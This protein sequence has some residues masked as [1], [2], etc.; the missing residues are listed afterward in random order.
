MNTSINKVTA[1]GWAA[2]KE[3]WKLL[4]DRE[5][6]EEP[7]KPSPH[8]PP[9]P[10]GLALLHPI[11]D[12]RLNTTLSAGIKGKW[13]YYS[14]ALAVLSFVSNWGG[15]LSIFNVMVAFLAALGLQ[16][17]TSAAGWELSHA[18][19]KRAA[20]FFLAAW[21]L[22]FAVSIQFDGIYFNGLHRAKQ[23]ALDRPVAIQDEAQQGGKA[24]ADIIAGVKKADLAALGHES[25]IL[26]DAG[27]KARTRQFQAEQR[28]IQNAFAL[29]AAR[30]EQVGIARA[31]QRK[32]LIDDQ[33]KQVEALSFDTSQ[34][35]SKKP[36]QAWPLIQQAYNQ[37]AN[38]HASI[39]SAMTDQKYDMPPCPQPT[40]AGAQDIKTGM[41]DTLGGP[42]SQ[43]FHPTLLQGFFAAI[44]AAFELPPLLFSLA[45]ASMRRDSRAKK[46]A[47][48]ED[49]DVSA[50]AAEDDDARD[51]EGEQAAESDP[52]E[53]KLQDYERHQR[54]VFR[55]GEKLEAD[56]EAE[57]MLKPIAQACR[58][59]Q[60]GRLQNH[61]LRLDLEA[62]EENVGVQ[63]EYAER[64]GIRQEKVEEM[65]EAEFGEFQA[66]RSLQR[67][68]AERE[69]ERRSKEAELSIA[70]EITKLDA[71]LSA[72]G[73]PA[74]GHPYDDLKAV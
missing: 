6:L 2:V 7:D 37:A 46:G 42:L 56:A 11:L 57:V 70:R 25:A 31:N 40:V 29:Q 26:D 28:P 22:C 4:T 72:L 63:R 65:V 10:T 50:E 39:R 35:A 45:F 17:A 34:I 1:A 61:A 14:V 51:E 32:E 73:R 67:K 66:E 3:K 36:E 9:R 33:I 48:S 24:V 13:F 38:V 18:V 15:F 21:M 69:R 20:A 16:I 19:N 68:I 41:S 23:V 60:C 43:V 27:A 5:H 53:R 44:A 8:K 52:D 58:R 74:E 47:R 49:K 54:F 12:Y 64:I 30:D 62:L 59:A 71:Q 55:Y